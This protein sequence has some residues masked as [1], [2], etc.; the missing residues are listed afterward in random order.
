MPD[1]VE[2]EAGVSIKAPPTRISI[3]SASSRCGIR[4]SLEG[5][6]QRPPGAAALAL[7]QPGAEDAVGDQQQDRPPRA[8][9]LADLDD[10]VD[11]DQRHHDEGDHQQ[12]PREAFVSWCC[13]CPGQR[14]GAGGCSASR[15][16]AAAQ[17]PDL[18]ASR[19][20]SPQR[21]IR[22][23]DSVAMCRLIF[24]SPRSRSTNSIGT[25]TTRSPART[26]RGTRGRPG[27]R[28][29][30]S[31]SPRGGSARA[32]YG[33]TGGSRPWRRARRC[34]AAR[35]CRSCRPARAAARCS[36]QLTM[37]PPG[38]QREPITRSASRERVE[39]PVQLLGL[40]GPVGVHLAD[41]VVAAL[42]G[43]LEAVRGTPRPGPP[44]VGRCSTETCGSLARDRVGERRR[45]RPVSCRRRRG[46]PR[47]AARPRRRSTSRREVERLVV[48]RN[49][50]HDPAEPGDEVGRHAQNLSGGECR[51][52]RGSPAGEV[53]GTT[54]SMRTAG[55]GERRDLRTAHALAG[56]QSRRRC[57]L[58]T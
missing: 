7:D 42:Q 11:L 16:A 6:A 19:S 36:G 23:N 40:V 56:C 31:R 34:R 52:E 12:P 20:P 53:G 2:D 15:S 38:T 41:H 47:R 13:S 45:C 8:D 43:H 14:P 27:R 57:L 9:D 21:V 51:S 26:R 58:V 37:L 24:E 30:A 10:H 3:P 55:R 54:S 32:S 48:G 46:R 33:G 44:C 49:D 1:D 22:R 5:G 18:P 17:A 29:P 39:Q 35:G 50:H 4:P 25:S 28:S